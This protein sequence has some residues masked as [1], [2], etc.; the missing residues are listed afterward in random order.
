M[1]KIQ[2]LSDAFLSLAPLVNRLFDQYGCGRSTL[3]RCLKVCN[4]FYSTMHSFCIINVFMTQ[5]MKIANI[6]E[7]LISAHILV[8][9]VVI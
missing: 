6:P 2:D 8:N 5:K 4:R 3:I 1:V 9:L 7:Y